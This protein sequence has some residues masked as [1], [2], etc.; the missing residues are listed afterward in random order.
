MVARTQGWAQAQKGLKP[1]FIFFYF[2]F[3]APWQPTSS[4]E[5]SL[6]MVAKTRAWAW[7]L[8]GLKLKF[9]VFFFRVPC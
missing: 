3:Q 8:F 1:K 9:K 5:N 6:T 2:S 4:V 7:V